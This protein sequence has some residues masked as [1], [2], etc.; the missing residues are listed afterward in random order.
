MLQQTQTSRVTS[1]YDEF[2]S[3]FPDFF[4]LA[5]APLKEVL[6]VWQGL[7]Y[8]R[9]ALAL[10]RT[11]Q[12]IVAEFDGQLPSDPKVLNRFPSIGQYTAA[13]V[14]AIAFN[15]PTV[16]IE[17]NIRTVFLYFFFGQSNRTSDRDILS[18]VDA[19]LDRENPREWYYAL[20]DFGAMLKHQRNNIPRSKQHRQSY[21]RGSNREIRGHIIRLL[22]SKESVTKQE[23]VDL[24]RAN[25]ERVKQ[26]TIQLQEEGL[27]DI[28]G[29]QIR[30][31]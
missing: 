7:G 22:L 17:T 21:F 5:R 30:I 28:R 29:K 15:K 4:E 12:K 14:A 8:N 6:R 16:L 27:I 10:Q 3:I 20:F 23:L 13:A 11:A 1:K 19:T 18:L 2:I 31:R 25:S 9:R 26:I 24:F